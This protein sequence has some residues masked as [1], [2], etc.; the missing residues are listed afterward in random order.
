ME[1]VKRGANVKIA[2]ATLHRFEEPCI[3]GKNGSGTVF[4]S[5]CNLSC[6]FCQNYQISSL[7]KG[8]EITVE[9]LSNIFIDL[10]K[11]GAN[12][13]NLVTG[14]A[15]VPHIMEALELAKKQNLT[16]PII[17]NT[18]GYESVE[19]IRL[20]NGYVDIYLP[21]LKYSYSELSKRLSDCEDYFDI[22]TRAVREMVKQVGTPVFDENGLIKR[23]VIVRHLIL[24]NH[25]QNSKRVLKWIS[26]KLPNEIY[27]SIMAQYFPSYK[28]MDIDDINRKITN[29]E[30]DEIKKYMQ[31]LGIVNGYIQD[32]EENEEQYVPKF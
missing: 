16:I 10:Q 21:D 14:F 2:L 31:R 8:R 20:L 26:N 29:N 11:R 13:I 17:Y 3:S 22:A 28:A 19:T 1:D 6:K 7:G 12:N 18:S 24:P 9:E 5:G 15:Y 32:I 23:G 30:L 4:F 27:V 25:I